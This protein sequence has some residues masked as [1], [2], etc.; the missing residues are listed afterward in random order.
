MHTP[1]RLEFML[2]P[3]LSALAEAAWT[4]DTSKD[5]NDFQERLKWVIHFF[6]EE[7]I[8]LFDPI[9]PERISEVK[10]VSGKK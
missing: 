2:F 10:G 4:V 1:E 5:Y 3:R 8:S 6:E 7:G 9:N